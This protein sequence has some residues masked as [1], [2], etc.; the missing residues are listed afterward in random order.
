MARFGFEG[1]ADAIAEPGQLDSR[2]FVHGDRWPSRIAKINFAA[3]H[4]RRHFDVVRGR[5]KTTW[6]T[7]KCVGISGPIY[8]DPTANDKIILF[9]S[10]LRTEMVQ[11]TLDVLDHLIAKFR[12]E[13]V[14]Q[15]ED[16]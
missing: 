8:V 14:F 13:G 6:M 4:V 3:L 10:T 9:L 12:N 16:I 5:Q 7:M 2:R 15:F 1:N 11:V